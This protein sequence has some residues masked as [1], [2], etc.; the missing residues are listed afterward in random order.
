[1]PTERYRQSIVSKGI[2]I[3][4]SLLGYEYLLIMMSY[5]VILQQ[6]QI[7]LDAM[8]LPKRK[9]AMHHYGIIA[10]DCSTALYQI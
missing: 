5:Q 1:M 6:K 8:Q 10:V 3:E 2:R 7:E 9:Y 4:E